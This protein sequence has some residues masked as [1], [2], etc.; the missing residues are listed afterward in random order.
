MLKTPIENK[1][2]GWKLQYKKKIIWLD[3]QNK[4]ID[5]GGRHKESG[6]Q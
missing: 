4:R 3:E 2:Y 1:V 5:P 6:V